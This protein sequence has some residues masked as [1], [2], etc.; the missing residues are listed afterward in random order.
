[1]TEIQEA[2]QLLRTADAVLISASNGL[3]ISEGYNIFANNAAFKCYFGDFTRQYG[4]TSILQGVQAM[5]PA[6]AHQRF[7]RQLK[8]L[9]ADK[10]YFVVTSNADQHFQ[11]NG[12]APQKIWEVEGDFFN[13]KMQ[14]PEWEAQQ[15]ACQDFIRKCA[16]R[17]LV[18][19]ELGIGA[20]NQLIKA[21]LM[22]MVEAH[23]HWRYITLNLP[24][25]INVRPAIK[26]Q[27]VALAGDLT[28]T[29]AQLVK[30]N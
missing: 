13:L 4:I 25:E 30:E 28:Q 18:Q 26:D 5:L 17:Q 20:N 9:L 6:P 22:Q 15:Q 24:Q 27:T 29:L 19:L 16:D 14:S 12:F 3:S 2:Q 23:P 1:M 10:D 21:P 8:Q 11:Q 7:I